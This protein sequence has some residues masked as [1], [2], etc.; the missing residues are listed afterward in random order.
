MKISDGIAITADLVTVGIAQAQDGPKPL[1][2]DKNHTTIGFEVP[3]VG[4]LSE[5]TGKFV[6][7][8]IQVLWNEDPAESSVSVTI[9]VASVDTGID[10]RDD[11]LR[12]PSFFDAAKH[13]TITFES[14]KIERIDSNYVAHGTLTIK[15]TSKEIDLP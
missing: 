7:F 9:Q 13:P 10:D 6:D 3:I 4:D 1:R 11:D 5:V 12:S 2:I 8:D 14:D 15:G